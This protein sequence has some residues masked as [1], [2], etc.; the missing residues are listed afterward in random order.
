MPGS[1][2]SAWDSARAAKSWAE[3]LLWGV[4]LACGRGLW[5]HAFIRSRD[6]YVEEISARRMNPCG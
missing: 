6:F 1:N 5:Y 2:S 3:L 4:S